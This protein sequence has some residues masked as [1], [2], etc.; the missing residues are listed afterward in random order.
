LSNGY[1]TLEESAKLAEYYVQGGCDV[2]EIDLPSRNPYLESDYIANR[3]ATA[4]RACD[5]YDKYMENILEI[6]RRLP[7]TKLFILSYE[8]TVKEIGIEKFA[9]FCNSND[10]KDIIFVGLEN[11]DIKNKL[12]EKGLKVSC[13]VQS[14]MLP[15]EVESAKASNGFVYMQAKAAPEKINPAFPTL[16]DCIRYLREQGIERPIYC[17]VGVSQPSDFKMVK[18]AKGDGAFVGSTILKLYDNPE[19]LI[20]TIKSFKAADIDKGTSS[21]Q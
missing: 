8:N 11:E 12:I 4:L 2:I 1:P 9:D 10:M 18:D 20:E 6:R 17:G 21:R 5:D 14:M 7:N 15:E 3:M 13:Y 19:K 16:A